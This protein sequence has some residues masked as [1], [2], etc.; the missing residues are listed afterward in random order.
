MR[1]RIIVAGKPALPFTKTAVEDYM[2]RLSRH[3]SCEL[4]SVR[5]AG[6]PAAVSARLLAASEDCYRIALDERGQAPTTRQ[7]AANFDTLENDAGVRSLAF[8]IG[9][10]DGHSRELREK[11]DMILALSNMTLQHELALTVLLEQLYR[12]AMIKTNSPYH[13]D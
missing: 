4:V 2:K 11:S 8:L 10:A 1:I 6:S 9:A 12:I 3:S 7:L 13:R 5:S